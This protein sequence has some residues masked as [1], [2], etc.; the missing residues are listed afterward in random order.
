MLSACKKVDLPHGK[1]V[2]NLKEQQGFRPHSGC[3][4]VPKRPSERRLSFVCQINQ[5]MDFSASRKKTEKSRKI[6]THRFGRKGVGHSNDF[7]IVKQY[8]RVSSIKTIVNKA[9]FN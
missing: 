2:A 1:L 4:K 8:G 6:E 7:V 3:A 5:I 9:V